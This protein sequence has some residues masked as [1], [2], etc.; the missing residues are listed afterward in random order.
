[1]ARFATIALLV[2]C[3][4]ACDRDAGREAAGTFKWYKP[5]AAQVQRANTVILYEGLPHQ[6]WQP[7]AHT[8][9]LATKKTVVLGEDPFYAEPLRLSPSDVEKLRRLY[10]DPS[11][12][13]PFGGMKACGGYHPDYCIEWH[14]DTKKLF[15]QICFG[16]HEMKTFS[17]G[18]ILYCDIS[19]GAFETFE[20]ILKSYRKNRPPE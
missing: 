6:A 7:E 19:P 20:T 10:C 9:E 16:C 13:R 2:I 18:K 15:V 12:F 11:S 14:A 17:D 8:N 1:M 5:F 4:V 3:V